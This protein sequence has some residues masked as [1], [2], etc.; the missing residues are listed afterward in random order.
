MYKI[1]GLSSISLFSKSTGE[2]ILK[3][4]GTLDES[5]VTHKPETEFSLDKDLN[6]SINSFGG[7]ISGTLDCVNSDLM[8]ILQP[9]TK[10]DTYKINM[11][12]YQEFLVQKRKHKR[13]RINKK[14]AK[15]YGY[16]VKQVK[17][18]YIFNRCKFNKKSREFEVI[19]DS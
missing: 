4:N 8:K 12:G 19:A 15:I 5:N 6:F 3:I 11:E 2:E 17:V 18:E 9:E 1:G 7:S 13:K 16:D 14:W 10:D